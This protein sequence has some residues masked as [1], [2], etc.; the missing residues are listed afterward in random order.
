MLWPSAVQYEEGTLRDSLRR[1]LLELA[2][3]EKPVV[4]V[5]TKAHKRLESDVA[6]VTRQLTD[7]ITQ[8]M[9]RPPLAVSVTSAGK[10]DV[11]QLKTALTLLQSRA[12]NVFFQ[13][14]TQPWRGQLQHAAQLMQIMAGQ[15]FKDAETIA[16]DIDTF[17]QKMAEFD[18]RL[19]RET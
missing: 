5:V 11:A 13:S 12:E 18:Q 17:E 7:E 4:L 19:Q 10:R 1:A 2:V 6:N 16:A 8:L 14:V 9:G 3:Q 15:D